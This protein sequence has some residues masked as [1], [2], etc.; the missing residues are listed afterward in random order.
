GEN[1]NKLHP[2]CLKGTTEGIDCTNRHELDEELLAEIDAACTGEYFLAPI[3]RRE[4]GLVSRKKLRCPIPGCGAE[5]VLKEYD[6]GDLECEITGDP[7]MHAPVPDENC[8]RLRS[9]E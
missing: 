6:D 9:I 1:M 5:S 4:R 8:L 7:V 3:G 2:P